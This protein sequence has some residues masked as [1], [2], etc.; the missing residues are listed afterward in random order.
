MGFTVKKIKEILKENSLRVTVSRVAVAEVLVKSKDSYLTS[1]EIHLKISKKKDV[2]CDLVS[3]Y[4][5]LA[6]YEELGIVKKSEFYNDATRYALESTEGHSAHHH[7][8]FFKCT[9]CLTIE[10]FSDC[11]VS[12]KEKEL[13]SNGYQNLTHHLEI[14]GLCPSC[15]S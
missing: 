3:V 13:E 15:A 9:E 7:E 5:V 8:H 6:K 11:F 12:K 4:R 2:S 10:P 1:E 14:S